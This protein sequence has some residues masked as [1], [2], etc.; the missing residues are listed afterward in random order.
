MPRT[1]KSE[2]TL[3]ERARVRGGARRGRKGGKERG[4]KGGRN[5]G[6]GGVGGGRE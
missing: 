5:R 6:E 3:H 4:A 2:G 1:G